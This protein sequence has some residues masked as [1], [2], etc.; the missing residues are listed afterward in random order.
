MRARAVRPSRGSQP[1]T[2]GF[3]DRFSLVDGVDDLSTHVGAAQRFMPAVTIRREGSVRASARAAHSST[4][5]GSRAPAR[6]SRA[7]RAF[8]VLS[9]DG[10]IEPAVGFMAPRT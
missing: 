8:V 1:R 4:G 9:P 5:S 2:S 6:N 10:R 3:A 7:A